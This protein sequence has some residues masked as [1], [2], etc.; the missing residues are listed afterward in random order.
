MR[1]TSFLE[2]RVSS[3]IKVKIP[4]QCRLIED[5]TELAKMRGHHALAKDLSLGGLFIKTVVPMKEGDIYGLEISMTIPRS[6]H[7]FAFAE[8]VR[9]M[10]TGAG[11]KLLLLADEDHAALKEFLENSVTE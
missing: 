1:E 7:V 10:K 11:I 6:I 3:R 2:K 4:V 8:V 5:K 9:A